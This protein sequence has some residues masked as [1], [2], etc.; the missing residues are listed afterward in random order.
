MLKPMD[1]SRDYLLYISMYEGTVGMVLV[2][3]DDELHEHIV[4]YL[5]KNLVDPEISTL[6][7]RSYPWHYVFK[8]YDTMCTHGS[9]IMTLCI[10]FQKYYSC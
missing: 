5:S 7:L 9:N 6:M 3:E 10:T 2:H 4:Y 1:Y 8:Y